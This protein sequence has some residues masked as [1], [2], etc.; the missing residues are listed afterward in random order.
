MNAVGWCPTCRTSHLVE[1]CTLFVG[2]ITGW[3]WWSSGAFPEFLGS[4]ES[5]VYADCPVCGGDV[6]QWEMTS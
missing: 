6:D 3:W 4:S 2:L 1:V 5:H